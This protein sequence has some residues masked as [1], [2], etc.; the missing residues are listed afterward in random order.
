MI[1]YRAHREPMGWSTQAWNRDRHEWPY[2]MLLLDQYGRRIIETKHA[3][4]S[5]LQME[6]EVSAKRIKAGKPNRGGQVP[7]RLDVSGVPE[8]VWRKWMKGATGE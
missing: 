7:S 4:Q 3:S 8:A 6:V 1:T 5:S 2:A